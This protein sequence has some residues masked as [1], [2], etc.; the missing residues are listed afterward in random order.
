M[1]PTPT[2]ELVLEEC[3]K[4][5]NAIWNELGDKALRELLV[6]FPRNTDAS[7]V[8]VKVLVLN[9]LYSTRVLDNDVERLAR[10]ITGLGIDRLL[11]QGALDAVERIYTC[12]PLKNYYSFATKFCSWHNP[13]A[14]PIYDSYAAKCLWT[15]MKQEKAANQEPFRAFTLDSLWHY[16]KFVATVTA[17]RDRYGL[18][19]LTFRQIDK[20]LWFTGGRILGKLN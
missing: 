16:D 2:V 12:P 18:D 7:H 20:F 3:L 6:R 15:Y 13:N 17:F 14:Y 9:K 8:L 4:F 1:L 5:D 19:G 11:E 10:H